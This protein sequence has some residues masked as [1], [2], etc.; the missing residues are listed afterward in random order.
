MKLQLPQGCRL[1]LAVVR[2]VSH[3]GTRS[4][5]L[6]YGMYPAVVQHLPCRGMTPTLSW[7]GMYPEA[8]RSA[9]P[10]LLLLLLLPLLIKK[11]PCVL[12]GSKAQ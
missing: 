1:Y 4:T 7:Y 10:L 11:H 12:P 6:W 9:A 3:G 2:N 8:E 5:S